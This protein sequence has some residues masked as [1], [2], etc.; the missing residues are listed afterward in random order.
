MK[1]IKNKYLIL[2]ILFISIP[3]TNHDSRCNSRYHGGIDNPFYDIFYRY[4]SGDKIAAKQVLLGLF[5]NVQYGADARVNH[6][7]IAHIEK[8]FDEAQNH[9]LISL[10]K[11]NL[12]SLI[13]LSS[14]YQEK[15]KSLKE[16]F[17]LFESLKLKAGYWIEYEQAVAAMREKKEKKALAHL[18]KAYKNGFASPKLL[19]A[20]SIF[21]P[22]YSNREFNILLQKIKQVSSRHSSIQNFLKIRES[23]HFSGKPHW[24]SVDLQY[25]SYLEKNRRFQQAEKA[26]LSFLSKKNY[27]R[28]QSISLFWL[29]RILAGRGKRKKAKKYLTQ[30]KE[31]LF[32]REPDHTDYKILVQRCYQDIIANDLDLKKL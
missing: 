19:L 14:L 17:K 28:E 18:E 30:F 6:A 21:K 20:E 10:K 1:H 16:H 12:L 23:Q 7:L 25:I 22:L 4:H 5:G 29:T 24:L 27:F 11:G 2:L 26:L 13:Y 3:I 31:H 9:L 32:S 8:N 15:D